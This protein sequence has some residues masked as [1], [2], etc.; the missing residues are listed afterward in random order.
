MADDADV[1]DPIHAKRRIDE[2][3]EVLK[4]L[5]LPREQQNERSSHTV[6]ALLNL[7]AEV[8]WSEASNP[9]CGITP[10]MEFFRDHYGKVYAPNTRETVRRFTIHQFMEAGLVI[11]NPDKPAR[12]V[13]SPDTVYQIEPD[14]LA[15]LRRYGSE[16]WDSSLGTYL[17]SRQTLSMIHFNRERFLGPY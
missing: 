10:M 1:L 7:Q 6:L 11:A 4:S 17:E 14:A 13:N 3:L 9:L 5:G 15:L 2:A 12:P 8:D 16:K